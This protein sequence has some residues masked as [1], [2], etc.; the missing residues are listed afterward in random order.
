MRKRAERI[1]VNEKTIEIANSGD[2][3]RLA[4][5]ENMDNNSGAYN[6]N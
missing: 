2:G 5:I 6:D 3:M 1:S 4:R